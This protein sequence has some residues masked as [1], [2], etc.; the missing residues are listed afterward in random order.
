[1]NVMARA[2]PAAWLGLARGGRRSVLALSALLL[3]IAAGMGMQGH[4]RFPLFMLLAGT[5]AGVGIGRRS[6]GADLAAGRGVLLFQRPVTPL[7]HYTARMVATLGIFAGAAVLTAALVAVAGDIPRPWVHAVGATYWALLMLVIATALSAL[8]RR[9]DVE[10]LVLLFV[11]STTQAL[12]AN[13]LGVPGLRALL[14]WTLIPIDAVFGSWNALARGDFSIAP[15]HGVQL[16]LQPLAWGTVLVLRLRR[17]DIGAADYH[18]P[19]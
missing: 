4:E 5:V 3:A 19:G 10:L 12:I 6:V 2:F 8:S 9:F 16:V 7:A 14:D 15:R 11:L 18:A 1:M 13:A 17:I